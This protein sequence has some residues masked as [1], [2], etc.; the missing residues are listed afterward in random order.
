MTISDRLAEANIPETKQQHGPVRALFDERR[1]DANYSVLMVDLLDT[2]FA[3]LRELFERRHREY[4]DRCYQAEVT[5]RDARDH[6][7]QL[8]KRIEEVHQITQNIIGSINVAQEAENRPPDP[9]VE[10]ARAEHRL[11]KRIDDLADRLSV[12]HVQAQG[13]AKIRA[14][15]ETAYGTAQPIMHWSDLEGGH[16]FDNIPKE[17]FDAIPPDSAWQPDADQTAADDDDGMIPASEWSPGSPLTD[18]PLTLDKVKALH[19]AMNA[20]PKGDHQQP[21]RVPYRIRGWAQERI[22]ELKAVREFLE[23]SEFSGRAVDNHIHCRIRDL[24]AEI[25]GEDESVVEEGD[26]DAISPDNAVIIEALR[27]MD[28]KQR[29]HWIKA[30]LDSPKPITPAPGVTR[31]AIPKQWIDDCRREIEEGK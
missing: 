13:D 27:Q 15:Q 26:D 5:A 17:A 10:I 8:A 12:V 11:A 24:Q 19:K 31:I 30:L 16:S 21:T 20:A 3:E 14:K 1:N 2:L 28:G 23:Q 7:K 4:C 9:F 25:D 18:E 22:A 29:S 6:G